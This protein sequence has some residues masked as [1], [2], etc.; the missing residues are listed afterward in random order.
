VDVEENEARPLS[1][2]AREGVLTAQHL[3]HPIAAEAE[4]F[5]HEREERFVVV[6]DEDEAS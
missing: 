2:H 5:S 6:D 1:P 3:A 4:E